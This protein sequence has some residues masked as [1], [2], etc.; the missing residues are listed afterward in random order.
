MKLRNSVM[1]N[2]AWEGGTKQ[3]YDATGGTSSF[4][5]ALQAI[6]GAGDRLRVPLPRGRWK[7]WS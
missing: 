5:Q 1:W 2:I 6:Q 7:A 4:L 3:A